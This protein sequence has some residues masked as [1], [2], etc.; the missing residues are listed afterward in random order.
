MSAQVTLPTIVGQ[1]E[2]GAAPAPGPS[3][4]IDN[5]LKVGSTFEKYKVEKMLA[6]GGMGAVYLVRHTTLDDC[7][8]L[9][10]LFPHIAVQNRDFVDRFIREAKY[11][12]KIRHPNLIRV[13][14]AGC[15]AMT[16]LY[17]LV[18]DYVPNGNL[19]ERLAIQGRILPCG[20]LG[21]VQQVASALSAAH[22][23]G[24]IHRDIKPENIMFDEKGEVRLTD[25]GIA[26]STNNGDTMLTIAVSLMGTPNYMSP[27]QVRDSTSIDERAD[28]YS[29]GIVLYEM[30]SG[31]CP[32]AEKTP[33]EILVRVLSDEK[34]APIAEKVPG[35]SAGLAKLVHGM[36]EKNRDRRI[37]SVDT[38]LRRIQELEDHQEV[39][40]KPKPSAT[41]TP[42]PNAQRRRLRL[43]IGVLALLVGVLAAVVLLS[44][45]KSIIPAAGKKPQDLTGTHSAGASLVLETQQV[46]N[47]P[48]VVTQQIARPPVVVTQRV[49]SPPVL[50]TQQVISPSA[51]VTQGVKGVR[52]PPSPAEVVF[53]PVSGRRTDVL[54]ALERVIA[55]RPVRLRVQLGMYAQKKA[56]SPYS[57]EVLLKNVAERLRVAGVDF[58][59]VPDGKYGDI[60]RRIARLQSYEIE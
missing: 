37:D 35:I 38:L 46:I 9:K 48:A 11:A 7:F 31:D 33:Q 47:P 2:S 24:I 15:N 34:A 17:Y 40:A 39:G 53:A 21:I 5:L 54:D 4:D 27:E 59:L 60:T 32:F 12:S 19:R 23:A 18:M 57:F 25:L 10:V 30:L 14:D 50:E 36:I 13:H 26:K 41:Q 51:V 45:G 56:L 29:L 20:V 43:M 3:V 55:S 22:C 16:G 44:S 42:S 49:V 6:K 8:A 28:I 58:V 1:S 52:L